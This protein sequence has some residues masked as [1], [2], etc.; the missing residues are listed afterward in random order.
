MAPSTESVMGSLPRDDAGVG[1][2]TSDTSMQ[3][4]GAL[5]VGVLGTVLNF[6]YQAYLAPLLA[7]H[8]LPA[9]VERL[10]LGSLGGALAVA[11]HVPGPRGTGLAL[12]ARRGFV[13]G[14]DRGFLVAAA[15]VVLAGLIVLV[16]LPNR[17]RRVEPAPGANG[18]GETSGRST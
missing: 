14:M 1:S 6:R 8:S 18:P 11:G 10:I 3:I 16:A 9:A 2:A 5:G 7:H 4:G 15:V 12:V 13:S 17:G